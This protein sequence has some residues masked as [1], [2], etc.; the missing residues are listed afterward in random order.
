MLQSAQVVNVTELPT[1]GF[2]Y[3]LQVSVADGSSAHRWTMDRNVQVSAQHR[4][5]FS[6]ARFL[7][8]IKAVVAP[9]LAQGLER[10]EA[11]VENPKRRTT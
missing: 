4:R 7:E 2:L 5:P 9:L 3:V 6:A 10:P 1:T 11:P 8:L